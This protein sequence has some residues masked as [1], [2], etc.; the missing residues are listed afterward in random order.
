MLRF[1]KQRE[2]GF[3]SDGQSQDPIQSGK[4][5][6]ICDKCMAKLSVHDI[7]KA[8]LMLGAEPIGW[9]ETPGKKDRHVCGML[10][11]TICHKVRVH[12]RVQMHHMILRRV[13]E[14]GGVFQR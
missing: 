9:G 3:L 10:A 5:P 8:T 11:C 14:V 2:L 13:G 12:P 6:M 1:Q 7:T 4:D